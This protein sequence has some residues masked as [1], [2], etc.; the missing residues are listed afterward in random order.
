MKNL[1]T[2]L[3]SEKFVNTI[4]KYLAGLL[5]Y[6][7]V[8][9]F[10]LWFPYYKEYLSG[11]TLYVLKLLLIG[12][13]L[14][15]FPINFLSNERFNK[16]LELLLILDKMPDIVVSYSNDFLDKR[17]NQSIL[18]EREKN[19]LLFALVKFFYIPLMTNFT[20][21]NFQGFVSVFQDSR[22][23]SIF[24]DFRNNFGLILNIFFFIDTLVFCFGYIFEA[25]FLKN[26]LRSVEPTFFGWV[27]ALATYPPFNSTTGKILGWYS[28]DNFIFNNAAVDVF[29]K[30]LVVILIGI[31]VWASLSLGA[32][33]S[34]LTNRGIVSGG[35]YKIV[36]HPAYISKVSA[37]WIMSLPTFTLMSFVSMSCWTAL[38]YLR[39]V[40]EE[41]HLIADKDYKSYVKKTKY[42]FVR[43][44]I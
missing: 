33:A 35:A 12:Y 43:G 25:K 3:K 36:R 20:T 8:F 23:L 11:D 4:C 30:I 16:P 40:T 44:V 26:K 34:N 38:Y 13:A 1:N 15:G 29:F 41:R 22:Y 6:G 5:V 39:A 18:T 17:K 31:Y 27:V 42:R 37:W 32:K 10:Y 28:N 21:G 14:L 2:F 9:L 7:G 19:I 24:T